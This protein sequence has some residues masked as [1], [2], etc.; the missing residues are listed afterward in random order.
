MDTAN[1][2]L[3]EHGGGGNP[4]DYYQTIYE[5]RL[6]ND[7]VVGGKTYKR[8]IADVT[9]RNLSPFYVSRYKGMLGL[10]REDALLQRLWCIPQKG[11]GRE[12]LIYDASWQ[13]GDTVHWVY[14][15]NISG[16]GTVTRLDST[17]IKGQWHKVFHMATTNSAGPGFE[18][19]EGIGSTGGPAYPASPHVFET[20][21]MLHCFT[22]NGVTPV[23]NPS[24]A[25]GRFDN[26]AS[27]IVTPLNIVPR[28]AT[29]DQV[30]VVP[31]PGGS[32]SRLKLPDGLSSGLLLVTDALGRRIAELSFSATR[33]LPIGQYLSTPGVYYYVLQD[34]AT[35]RRFNGRFV[36]R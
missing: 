25:N 35:G 8:M 26:Q 18:F 6:A 28:A 32:E 14:S 10:Y 34:A 1:R 21:W 23:T 36:F 4:V 7:T 27:C 13:V 15:P 29:E 16:V 3:V 2:W 9:H 12:R 24:L 30:L 5:A 17:L 11:D 33:E 22:N 31:D 19:I 20:Q